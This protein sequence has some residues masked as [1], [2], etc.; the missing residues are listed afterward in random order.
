MQL[1]KC[2]KKRYKPRISKTLLRMVFETATSRYGAPRKYRQT[3]VTNKAATNADKLA[4]RCS[5]RASNGNKHNF[6]C[7]N[8]EYSML[9]ATTLTLHENWSI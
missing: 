7:N 4:T 9:K 6:A 8:L 2:N 5:K 1:Y 3:Q